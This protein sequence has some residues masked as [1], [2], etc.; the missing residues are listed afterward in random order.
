MRNLLSPLIC[1][2]LVRAGAGSVRCSGENECDLCAAVA[3]TSRFGVGR[4][5]VAC[6]HTARLDACAVDSG[7]DEL[8][9]QDARTILR[10]LL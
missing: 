2:G 1:P 4:D 9:A 3:G 6:A 8:F 10:E 7:G 5:G